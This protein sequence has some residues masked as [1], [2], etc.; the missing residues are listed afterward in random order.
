MARLMDSPARP[1]FEARNRRAAARRK[2]VPEEMRLRVLEFCGVSNAFRL[3]LPAARVSGAGLTVAVFSSPYT[4]R[5]S[6]N[7]TG[8]APDVVS[9]WDTLSSKRDTLAI[10]ARQGTSQ[11]S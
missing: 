10:R 3:V 6:G 7:A 8:A 11:F 4:N 5:I 2:R 9:S 1:G